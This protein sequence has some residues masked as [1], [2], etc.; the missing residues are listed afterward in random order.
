VLYLVLDL[1]ASRWNPA[2]R[3]GLGQKPRLKAITARST[4]SL[5]FERFSFA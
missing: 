4:M 2:F 1:G 3:V 5:I